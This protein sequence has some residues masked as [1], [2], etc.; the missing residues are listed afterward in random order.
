MAALDTD[1]LAVWAPAEAAG[2]VS[3]VEDRLVFRRPL[4]RAAAF[5]RHPAGERQQQVQQDLAET[6]ARPE[7]RAH[8]LATATLRTDESVAA[9]LEDSAWRH[10]D[11]V[12][13][14]RSGAGGPAQP[15]AAGALTP[16]GR[17]SG[18]SACGGRSRLEGTALLLQDGRT[19]E[20][21]PGSLAL[22]D[23]RCPYRIVLP[24]R[25]RAR[26]LMMPRALLR[27]EEG[28]LAALTATAVDDAGEGAAALLL[29]LL[30]GLVDEAVRACATRRGEL[31]RLAA[32]IL[33]TLALEQAGSRPAPAL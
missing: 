18:G 3:L 13:T 1:D 19:A 5:S 7:S 24:R 14:A 26:I 11:V 21:R 9:L 32:E 16:S 6:V 22:H 25:Q 29:P 33:G 27:L 17:G 30:C 12:G 20:L 4:A 2:L 23:A 28:Q 8:H 31:A 15:A 10:G